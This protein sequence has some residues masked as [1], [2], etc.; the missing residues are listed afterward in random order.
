MASETGGGERRLTMLLLKRARPQLLR[1]SFTIREPLEPGVGSRDTNKPRAR[2]RSQRPLFFSPRL[3][4][5][6]SQEV[7]VIGTGRE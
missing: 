7:L 6:P 2:A 1:A 5:N 4:L 3:V